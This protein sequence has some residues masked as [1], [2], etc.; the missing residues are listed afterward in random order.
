MVLYPLTFYYLHENRDLASRHVTPLGFL[1]CLFYHA[2]NA[3]PHGN[4]YLLRKQQECWV[5]L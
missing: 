5:P 1:S 3:V 4:V 2:C